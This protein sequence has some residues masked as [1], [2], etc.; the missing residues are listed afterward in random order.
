MSESLPPTDA[1][2]GPPPDWLSA[3]VDGELSPGDRRQ[4][5]A[6]LV[7]SPDA[8]R[9]V[10]QLRQVRAVL[11]E[12]PM[13]E[14]RVD[15]GERFAAASEQRPAERPS[16]PSERPTVAAGLS[17]PKRRRWWAAM[18]TGAAACVALVAVML[19]ADRLAPKAGDLAAVTAADSPI[20]AV[21]SD[22]I[23]AEDAA[24]PVAAA[25]ATAIAVAAEPSIAEIPAADSL[26]L[27]DAA[28]AAGT[29]GEPARAMPILRE[30]DVI[31]QLSNDSVEV[32]EWEVVD[33]Q[34]AIG[35]L[36][37]LLAVAGV[38]ITGEDAPAGLDG[39]GGTQGTAQGGNPGVEGGEELQA[40]YIE[41]DRATVAGVLA[42]LP[43]LNRSAADQGYAVA[44][45][46]VAMAGTNGDGL[47]DRLAGP[48][49]ASRAAP[50]LVS[51]SQAKTQSLAATP[52]LPAGPGPGTDRA[53]ATLQ[54]GSGLQVQLPADELLRSQRRLMARRDA[55]TDA[56]ARELMQTTAGLNATERVLIVLKAQM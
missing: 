33:V 23:V 49:V 12:L 27:G 14:T 24:A 6:A 35:E 4:V 54:N 10:E 37:V 8:R 40:V 15:F 48:A 21:E 28:I 39:R 53:A 18:A 52:E 42:K 9:T 32:I 1:A 46:N 19:Q 51:P 34:E 29:T 41:S 45:D 17:R 20:R 43:E 7:A 5:E 13:P 30:G 47:G 38:S 31:A 56:A 11:G 2:A 44:I 22:G 26:P 25:P 16:P 3:Y 36:R 55:T 50:D